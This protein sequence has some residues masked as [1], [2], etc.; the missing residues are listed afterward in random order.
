M[1]MLLAIGVLPLAPKP[2]K[3]KKKYPSRYIKKGKQSITKHCVHCG[4][5]FK[6]M[7]KNAKYCKPWHNPKQIERKRLA[8]REGSRW[9]RWQSKAQIAEFYKNCPEGYVVDHIIPLNHPD[10][11]GLHVI[12]NLQYLEKNENGLKSNLWDGTLDN[13][14]WK[15]LRKS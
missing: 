13:K 10:I 2:A 7:H 3:P 8:K 15:A 1:L 11:S 4:K 14:G 5:E 12:D 9:P 6:T